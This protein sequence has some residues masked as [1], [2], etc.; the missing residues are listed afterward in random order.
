MSIQPMSKHQ[1][2]KEV[3]TSKTIAKLY[4][5]AAT[6]WF[7][8]KGLPVPS[9]VVL[10]IDNSYKKLFVALVSKPPLVVG[11]VLNLQ[12]LTKPH[13]EI[14][15]YTMQKT[16]ALKTYIMADSTQ[17]ELSGFFKVPVLKDR[18]Q[19]HVG[20]RPSSRSSLYE[21]IASTEVVNEVTG[22]KFHVNIEVR[23]DK[24]EREPVV[25][26][27]DSRYFVERNQVGQ[28][29]SDYLVSTLRN[30][31]GGLILDGGVPAWQLTARNCHQIQEWI[32]V[33]Y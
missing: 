2:L 11:F 3:S 16:K 29:V 23:L 21:S 6:N 18:P 22:I 7:T 26:F 14:R 15:Q 1:A 33:V 5:G 28:F 30:H 4:S 13:S 17:F 32:R 20:I 10:Y 12:D 27:Y 24:S 25:A 19:G 31:Q 9:H 8:S